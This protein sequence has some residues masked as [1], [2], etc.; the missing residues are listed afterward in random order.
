MFM[1]FNGSHNRQLTSYVNPPVSILGFLQTPLTPSQWP[2]P[3]L[4]RSLCS[5]FYDSFVVKLSNV[6]SGNTLL[7]SRK[8][9]RRIRPLP[10]TA[11]S[12]FISTNGDYLIN[13]NSRVLLTSWQVT[14]GWRWWLRPYRSTFTFSQFWSVV[15]IMMPLCTVV[16]TVPRPGLCR[17]NVFLRIKKSDSV[18]IEP[19]INCV[20]PALNNSPS[21]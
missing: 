18:S 12:H 9:R 17:L 3:I 4:Q 2:R 20:G 8:A 15:C 13:R 19:N 6:F 1:F 16:I 21:Y 11:Q 7:R 14:P 10:T 5:A